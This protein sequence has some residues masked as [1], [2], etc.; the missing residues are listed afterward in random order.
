MSNEEIICYKVEDGCEGP[1]IF[2]DIDQAIE[3]LRDCLEGIDFYF[4]IQITMIK[5]TQEDFNKLPEL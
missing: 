5:K 4:P 1:V 3:Y 2:D